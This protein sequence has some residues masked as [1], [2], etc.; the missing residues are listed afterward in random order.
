MPP[1]AIRMSLA[2]RQNDVRISRR[3]PDYPQALPLTHPAALAGWQP[4][5]RWEGDV[6]VAYGTAEFSELPSLSR[7]LEVTRCHAEARL[8]L[9]KAGELTLTADDEEWLLQRAA[10]II[11]GYED[12]RFVELACHRPLKPEYM[13]SSPERFMSGVTLV[14]KQFGQATAF[15]Y[16]FLVLSGVRSSGDLVKYGRRI[17]E[18]FSRVIGRPGVAQ[19]LEQGGTGLHTLKARE[20]IALLRQALSGLW[21]ATRNRPG[22]VFLLTQVLDGFLGLRPGGTGTDYGLAVLDTIVLAKLGFS[23]TV[24]KRKDRFYL[25]VSTANQDTEYWDPLDPEAR[26]PTGTVRRLSTRDLFVEGYIQ[27]ARGY[28]RTKA[29]GHVERVARWLLGMKPDLPEALELLGIS[30]VGLGRPVEAIKHCTQ[31]LNANPRQPEAWLVQGNASALLSRWPEAI[32]CYKKAIALQVG[33]AEA[34]NNLGLVLDRNGEHD[35]AVGAFRE[36][37]RIDPKYVEAWYNLGNSLLE[38]NNLEPAVD[39]YKSA[40][41][42]NPGFAGAHYNLGQTYY[43][44]GRKR[45]AVAAYLA[46]IAANPK[47][48]GAW[49]NLGIAYRD[50]G[51]SER[52]V[53]A[54]ERAVALNPTLLR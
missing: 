25:A 9:V 54:I 43:R 41:E 22:S 49:H 51:E 15:G 10:G 52:A 36:A 42:H 11:P 18:A 27:L 4:Q 38:R 8:A 46:A 6:L 3:L 47:H 7:Q 32:D 28:V 20:R 5:L 50:L 39:A 45:Q 17:E 21:S 2:L 35:R 31:S 1:S 53:E 40:I 23:S 12:Q 29:Y 19:L 37:L 44:M 13:A 33:Y 24:L 16:G 34:Y 26:V 14:E 30:S 48:A